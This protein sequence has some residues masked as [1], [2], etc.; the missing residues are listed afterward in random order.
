MNKYL[1]KAQL[2]KKKVQQ[3]NNLP[4]KKGV[5]KPKI[6][7]EEPKKDAKIDIPAKIE[8]TEKNEKA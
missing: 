3:A 4:E 1:V 5:E 6:V 2:L 7:A 8:Q